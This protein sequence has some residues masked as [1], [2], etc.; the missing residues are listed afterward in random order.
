MSITKTIKTHLR[1][2]TMEEQ[3]ERLSLIETLKE[4]KNQVSACISEG[5]DNEQLE[6]LLNEYVVANDIAQVATGV[7]SEMSETLKEEATNLFDVQDAIINKFVEVGDYAVAVCSEGDRSNN[8]KA[9]EGFVKELSETLPNYVSVIENIMKVNTDITKVD[10]KPRSGVKDIDE[11]LL[12]SIVEMTEAF[13]KV[14]KYVN[15]LTKVFSKYLPKMSGHNEKL[16]GYVNS[17][18]E[19]IIV[20]D[21]IKGDHYC[22]IQPKFAIFGVGRTEDEAWGDAEEWADTTDENWKNSFELKPCTKKVYDYVN[23]NGTPDDWE[24]KDGVI[25]LPDELSEMKERIQESI[26]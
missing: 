11:G 24:E 3:H 22:I 19:E 10:V 6:D 1:E 4:K 7:Q 23:A 13:E 12:E 20:E 16:K 21:A 5:V 15:S 9:L 8:K 14:S 18:Y 2:H 26:I 17:L 25:A